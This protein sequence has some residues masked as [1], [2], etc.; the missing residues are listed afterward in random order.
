MLAREQAKAILKKRGWSYRNVAVALGLS[1]KSGYVH[2]AR[3][4]NGQRESTRLLSRIENLPN[5][6]EV[7]R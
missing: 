4:L 1:R 6:K 5:R 7:A 3:V 2:I